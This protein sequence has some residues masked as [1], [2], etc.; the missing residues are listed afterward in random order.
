MRPAYS[1]NGAL[2]SAGEFQVPVSIARN[3]V[4]GILY[5]SNNQL[6]WILLG[7]VLVAFASRRIQAAR[8]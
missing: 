6:G 2:G 7:D 1:L 8:S 4:T 5:A 3:P